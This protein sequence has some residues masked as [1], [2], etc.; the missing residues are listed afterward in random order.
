MVAFSD[1]LT[2]PKRVNPDVV[3]RMRV[4]PD[5]LSLA[6]SRA[7]FEMSMVN[8]NATPGAVRANWPSVVKLCPDAPMLKE[9]QQAP[10]RYTNPQELNG[11]LPLIRATATTVAAMAMI[12]G[13]AH[14]RI[15]SSVWLTLPDRV[16]TCEGVDIKLDSQTFFL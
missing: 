2:S 4:L 7:A 13:E 5:L 14:V 9:L 6:A 12:P 16:T 3:A 1:T 11:L 8:R 10:V 15:K